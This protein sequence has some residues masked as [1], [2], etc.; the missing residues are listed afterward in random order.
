MSRLVVKEL[1]PSLRDDFLWFFENVAFSDNP[2]WASCFCMYYSFPGTGREW[3]NTTTAENRSMMSG[4]IAK[5]KAQGLLAFMDGKPV[6]WCN[7]APRQIYPAI[8]RIQK[9]DTDEDEKIGSIVCF[10]ISPSQR[11][12]GVASNLLQAACDS[13]S[14]Q[15]LTTAEA[16]PIRNSNS[17]ADNF[18]GPL[19]MYLK[20]GFAPYRETDWNIIVRKQLS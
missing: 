20:A 4:L 10:V 2:E 7:A 3:D 11:G 13:F 15:G 14:K 5:G 16:Y 12:K 18:P 19:S 9:V 17:A 8:E 1:T 6:G